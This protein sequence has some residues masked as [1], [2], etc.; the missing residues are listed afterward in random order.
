MVIDDGVEA[1]VATAPATKLA[2]SPRADAFSELFGLDADGGAVVTDIER[3]LNEQANRNAASRSFRNR[4]RSRHQTCA[5]GAHAFVDIVLGRLRCRPLHTGADESERCRD[6]AEQLSDRGE[7]LARFADPWSHLRC[8]R[9]HCAASL[10]DAS[11]DL[12]HGRFRL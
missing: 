5:D 12:R 3:L 4:M 11:N 9:R 1:T 7:H 6:L 10:A 2:V 8:H